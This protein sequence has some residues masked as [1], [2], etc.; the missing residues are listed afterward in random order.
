MTM[1][2]LL[3]VLVMYRVARGVGGCAARVTAVMHAGR[4]TRIRAGGI[5]RA[6]GV[7]PTRPVAVDDRGIVGQLVCHRGL[8]RGRQNARPYFLMGRMA[9]EGAIALFTRQTAVGI[10]VAVDLSVFSL[11]GGGSCCCCCCSFP[12]RFC[13][14]TAS[15]AADLSQSTIAVGAAM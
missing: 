6:N 12:E 1:L 9:S 8:R 14:D 3:D 4:T 15:A 2:L 5:R 11:G 10:T 7:G 13:G